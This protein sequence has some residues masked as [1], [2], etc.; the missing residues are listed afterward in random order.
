[1]ESAGIF[2][3]VNHKIFIF[4]RK[5]RLSCYWCMEVLN[6]GLVNA[7]AWSYSRKRLLKV[8]LILKVIL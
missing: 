1:M 5:K 4:F 8:Y 7:A 2:L 6:S 3:L